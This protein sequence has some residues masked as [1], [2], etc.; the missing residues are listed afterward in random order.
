MASNTYLI[1]NG[2]LTTTI[3]KPEFDDLLVIYDVFRIEND[4]PLFLNDHLKR[5]YDGISKSGHRLSVTTKELAGQIFTLI[6]AEKRNIGNIKI[7]CSF[8]QQDTY[9]CYYAIFFIPHNYPDVEQY[10]SGV[11]CTTLNGC[12]ANP[13]IKVANTSIRVQSNK[14]IEEKRVFETILTNDE[15]VTEGSRSNIFFVRNEELITAPDSLVLCG[16]MRKK[17]LETANRLHIPIIF[18]AVR[19]NKL[20]LME[21]AFL[22]GTSLRILPVKRIDEYRFSVPHSVITELTEGLYRFYIDRDLGK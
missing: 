6:E 11:I 17:V 10:R 22:T 12:R 15:A 2:E 14:I 16:V 13:S 18:E 8:K 5:L 9:E 1:E 19:V 21:A 3:N 7:E 4:K 20:P